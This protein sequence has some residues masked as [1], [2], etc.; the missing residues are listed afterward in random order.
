MIFFIIWNHL[1]GKKQGRIYGFSSGSQ[2][3]LLPCK[4]TQRMGNQGRISWVALWA[5]WGALSCTPAKSGRLLR[6]G[7]RKG[8]QKKRKERKKKRKKER[9]KEVQTCIV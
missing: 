1:Q 8:S 7:R 9:Q 5:L 4:K 6:K 2:F 3:H